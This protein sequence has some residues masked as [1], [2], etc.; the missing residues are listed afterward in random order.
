MLYQWNLLPCRKAVS[1]FYRQGNR[2]IKA[3]LSKGKP[4]TVKKKD[5]P[6]RFL[7]CSEPSHFSSVPSYL[8]FQKSLLLFHGRVTFATEKI[9]LSTVMK[10][11]K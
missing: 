6:K 4:L 10:E 2:E 1:P 8:C 11:R 3:L 7:Y 9:K 5:L